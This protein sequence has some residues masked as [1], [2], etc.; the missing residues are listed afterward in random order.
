MW[1]KN[2]TVSMKNEVAKHYGDGYAHIPQ[3]NVS[4]ENALIPISMSSM[5]S[6]ADNSCHKQLS[7]IQMSSTVNR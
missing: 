3:D 7:R 1:D 2:A 5:I 4:A 6:T